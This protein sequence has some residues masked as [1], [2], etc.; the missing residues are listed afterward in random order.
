MDLLVVG[1]LNMDLILNNVESFPELEK[2]KIAQD[3]SLTLGSS[4]AIF[5]S[6]ISRLGIN[7]GF[8]G[9]IG[10]DAFG[11]QVINQLKNFGIDSSFVT[12]SATSKTGLTAIIRVG[13]S[14]AMVTYPGAMAHFSGKD[15]PDAA[16]TDATHMHIS[17][18]FLQPNIKKDLLKIVKKANANGLTVSIDPQW[19]PNEK[20]DINI[21]ELL[22]YIDFFLPNREEFL[23][24]VKSDN[25][26]EGLKKIGPGK[27][28]TIIVKNGKNGATYYEDNK[29][30]TVPTYINNN[31]ADAI[32]AGDSFNAGFIYQFLK[33]RSRLECVE[34]GNLTGA[35]STTKSGGTAAITSLNDV[36]KTAKD[37]FTIPNIDDFTG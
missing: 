24:L 5:A 14:R 7:T 29:I 32:G 31:P 35:V 1:E 23:N 2:E 18:I 12:T 19:D 33:G 10:D 15:I 25:I 11:S 27:K 8:C 34:L 20:W 13:D 30:T 3:M 37:K 36:L 28:A 22:D 6:N 26:E 4:S 17:S 16:F 21:N 9:M